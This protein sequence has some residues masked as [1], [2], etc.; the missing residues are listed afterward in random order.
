MKKYLFATA[1]LLSSSCFAHTPNHPINIEGDYDCTGT[2]IDTDKAFKC[3][4]N[5]KKTGQTYAFSTACND[6]TNYTST[7]IYQPNKHNI[8]LVSVNTKNSEETGVAVADVKKDGSMTSVWTYLHKTTLGHTNCA[9]R[10]K[11]PL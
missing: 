2:E 1:I 9:K 3:E 10:K 4:M 8:S 6:G 7:G 5:I 11:H